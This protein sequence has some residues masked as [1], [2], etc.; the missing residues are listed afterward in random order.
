MFLL[1]FINY[2]VAD[3]QE[4]SVIGEMNIQ[5]YHPSCNTEEIFFNY[6]LMR[7]HRN[8][9]TT[10]LVSHRLITFF[11]YTFISF[12]IYLSLSIS[13]SPLSF[14][15]NTVSYQPITMLVVVHPN[16]AIIFLR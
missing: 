14:K 1:L 4:P 9:A 2:F 16:M 10:S 8:L 13:L 12:S 6:F 15:M 11:P 3:K 5:E 7:M